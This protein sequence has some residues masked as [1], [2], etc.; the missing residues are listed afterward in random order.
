MAILIERKN[1]AAAHEGRSARSR[2]ARPHSGRGVA[3]RMLCLILAAA[4]V[5]S[6]NSTRAEGQGASEYDL[7]AAILYN[8]VKFVEWPAEAFSDDGA[9]IIVA[10]VGDDP[11]RGS[12]DSVVGKS[13]NGRQVVIRR[14]NAG[15]DLRSCHVLFVSSSEKKRLAQIVA[16]IDGAS[17]LTVGE[18]EGFES[19]GGMIRLTM[20]D[21]KVRFEINTGTARRARLRISSK[22][23]SL[24]K[25]VID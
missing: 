19:N 15:Q 24:A 7:K 18:M 6:I 20:E 4:V 8:F 9:P 16:S 22:L 2:L 21:N 17:V 5:T 1:R 23:L 10:V 13:A 14:L 12:L 3:V 25:R 11:F